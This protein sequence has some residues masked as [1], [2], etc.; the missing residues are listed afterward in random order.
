M[1]AASTRSR[2]GGLAPQSIS[3]VNKAVT[4]AGEAAPGRARPVLRTNSAR[5][6]VITLGRGAAVTITDVDIV[7][8]KIGI[9]GPGVSSQPAKSLILADVSIRDSAHHGIYGKFSSVVANRVSISGAAGNG[10]ALF[11]AKL[12]QVLHGEIRNCGGY[13]IAIYNNVKSA[14][15]VIDD[16]AIH[17]NVKGGVAVF[18]HAGLAIIQQSTITSNYRSAVWLYDADYTLVKENVLSASLH[19]PG[20]TRLGDGITGLLSDHIRITANTIKDNQRAGIA[21]LGGQ[22]VGYGDNLFLANDFAIGE[23]VWQGV[24]PD[25]V[26]M[27]GN[28]CPDI[29]A[30]QACPVYNASGDMPVPDAP[31]E[32]P[33]P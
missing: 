28:S 20:T 11:G 15:Y 16:E 25:V 1:E 33:D 19:E 18:G 23:D 12:A 26:D 3:V 10:L 6:S 13:G 27:G 31:S 5:K 21:N 8:G 7:G 22:D 17:D 4:L 29:V 32:I 30:A 24:L 14:L 9:A 2:A